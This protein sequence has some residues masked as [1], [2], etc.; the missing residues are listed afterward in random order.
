M[1]ADLFDL[2]DEELEAA[3]REAKAEE[4]SPDVGEELEVTEDV[5]PEDDDDLEQPEED[6]DDN[7]AEDEVEEEVDEDSEE[8]ETDPDEG[9]EVKEEATEEAKAGTETKPAEVRLYKFKA[10]GK[11]YEFSE[12]EMKEKFPIVFGQAMDYTRKMQAIKPWRKTIDAIESAK[13]GHEDVSLMI[14]VLRGDKNA[15]AEVLKKTGVDHLELDPEESR[16]VP[17]DY[18]RN[19]EALAIQDVIEEIKNDPEYA[20]TAQ[21]LGKEWDDSSWEAMSKQPKLIRALHI[22]MQNGMYDKVQ[23]IAEKL[24]LYE[25]GGKSDL[26]YYKEASRVYYAEMRRKELQEV[27]MKSRLEAEEAKKAKQAR[28]LAVQKDSE[29]QVEIKEASKKRKAAAPSKKAAG[30]KS[31]VDYLDESEEAFEEW[32]SALQ[33][34]M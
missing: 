2:S 27:E 3:F 13:L 24:K 29:K 26:E 15:I 17:K 19:E 25:G 34:R 23:P 22:D 12:E 5:E 21:V 33:D 30:R 28:L 18:G 8:T 10:N 14:D 4:D 31:G 1:A 7:E 20:K 16:Y 11:E 6:S 9:E 32:Y